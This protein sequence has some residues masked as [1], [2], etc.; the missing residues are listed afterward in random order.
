M[1]GPFDE[2]LLPAITAINRSNGDTFVAGPDPAIEAMTFAKDGM[3]YD[4][5]AR[6]PW[7]E[8]GV[9]NPVAGA[10]FAMNVNVSD[11]NG[12]VDSN[13]LPDLRVMVS[14]N[15]ARTANNRAH[16]GTWTTPVLGP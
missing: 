5:E 14:N 6:I 11:V 1:L 8:L 12:D 7:S 16:P 13:G 3:G 2:E 10:V 15:P 9:S 4:L